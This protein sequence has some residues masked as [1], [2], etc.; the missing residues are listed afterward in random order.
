MRMHTSIGLDDK[1]L[2][3]GSH[4]S[5]QGNTGKQDIILF[6]G[7]STKSKECQGLQLCQERCI[8]IHQIAAQAL[9]D[10]EN[11]SIAVP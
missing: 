1:H 3:D 4:I 10:D 11:S 5:G 8:E 2:A 7:A 9:H 6:V